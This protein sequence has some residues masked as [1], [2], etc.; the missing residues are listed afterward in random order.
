MSSLVIASVFGWV[1][2]YFI[3]IV[4]IV[5]VVVLVQAILSLA[6]DIDQQA[7][8]INSGLLEAE[9]NTD[10][11]GE[12]NTTIDHASVIVDNLKRARRALGG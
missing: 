3:A 8:D 4:V 12:L 11:L 5:A 10:P 2:G 6:S 9:R 7:Q 1:L